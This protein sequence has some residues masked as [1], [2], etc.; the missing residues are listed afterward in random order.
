MHRKFEAT[1]NDRDARS[2]WPL[3]LI[4]AT[5]WLV[6]GWFAYEIWKVL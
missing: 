1:P 4:I 5:T 6:I 2:L 3:I